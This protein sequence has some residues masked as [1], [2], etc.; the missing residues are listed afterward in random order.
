MAEETL[1]STTPPPPEVS[2]SP[3]EKPAET[4]SSVPEKESPVPEKE[5]PAKV[6]TESITQEHQQTETTITESENLKLKEKDT[7]SKN[8]TFIQSA[9]SFKVESNLLSDLSESERKSLEDFKTL[10]KQSISN[11]TLLPK[12][13]SSDEPSTSKSEIVTTTIESALNKE[14]NPSEEFSGFSIWGIP[15]LK[16][17]R[18]DVILL[19]FLRARDFKVNDAMI[20]LKNTLKWRDEFGIDKLV[21]EDLGDDLEKVVFM[22]GH[23]RDGHPVC[24]NVYGEFQNKELYGKT[25]STEE[26]REKFLRWRIQFLEKSIRKLDF[27]PAGVNTIFQV[28]DLKNAPGPGKRELRLATRKALH[29]LQDNYPEFVAKQVFIVFCHFIVLQLY[30]VSMLS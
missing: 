18:T 8:R 16:D 24:Y 20:M 26:K 22:H 11:N 17:E 27:D 12:S 5:S 6:E 3:A 15:L 25:F 23:D 21:D 2:E 4:E 13:S 1:P 9:V 7:S 10:L 29:L 19:K 14:E 28:N 30:I